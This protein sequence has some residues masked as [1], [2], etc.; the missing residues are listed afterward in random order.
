[1]DAEHHPE[2]GESPASNHV[3]RPVDAEHD[4]AEPDQQ[5]DRDADRHCHVAAALYDG[6]E[7]RD[8]E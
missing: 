8:A 6:D 2:Q 3:A 1:M 4:P 7:Q 5:R